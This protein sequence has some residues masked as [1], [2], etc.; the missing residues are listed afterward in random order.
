[1]VG[2]RSGDDVLPTARS[3]PATAVDPRR[4]VVA[5]RDRTAPMPS[6]ELLLLDQLN[7]R[8]YVLPVGLG[9]T[10][11]LLSGSV[12]ETSVPVPYLRATISR[13]TLR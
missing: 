1:M 12:E 7:T 11:T 13:T 2:L 8:L 3:T 4:S 6:R 5:F 10:V 9:G